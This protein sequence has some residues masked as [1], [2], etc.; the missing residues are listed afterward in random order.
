M[1][2]TMVGGPRSLRETPTIA[3]LGSG[4]GF[5]AMTGMSGAIKALSDSGILNCATYICGLS[6]SSWYISLL[7]ANA[8]FPEKGTTAIN[9]EI[10]NNIASS[11]FWLL[12]PE[13]LMRYSH[14]LHTKMKA[15]QPVTFTDFFGLLIGQT[16]LGPDR[17]ETAKLTDF[18]EKIHGGKAPM[19]ILTCL[20]VRPDMSA[21]TFHDW[22][23][24]SPF[25]IGM[26]K[27]G[28]FMKKSTG[29]HRKRSKLGKRKR[30]SEAVYGAIY[31]VLDLQAKQ[32]KALHRKR[33]EVSLTQSLEECLVQILWNLENI[34]REKF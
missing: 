16:L 21:M 22:V 2:N 23:E 17:M 7:Y 18:Q 25:E 6:G 13:C 9:A 33:A 26:A 20:H 1:R 27:Y 15:G 24:F 8:D 28:T 31:S 12:R 19:P 32:P 29:T 14:R 11:P 30:K 34:E 5:R 10:R 4:G 3:I